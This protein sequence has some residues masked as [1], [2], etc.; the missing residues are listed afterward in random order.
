MAGSKTFE[1]PKSPTLM[2]DILPSLQV[3]NVRSDHGSYK[4][5]D[6]PQFEEMAFFYLPSADRCL[7]ANLKEK[8]SNI[9]GTSVKL[10][11]VRG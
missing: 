1:T 9:C 6:R 3:P 7:L 2:N 4:Q 8:N 11:N 5:L 10:Q